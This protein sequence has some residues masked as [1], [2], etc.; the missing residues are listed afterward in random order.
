MARECSF[1]PFPQLAVHTRTTKLAHP[2]VLWRGSQKLTYGPAV[3]A[4]WNGAAAAAA[5]QDKDKGAKG[6][7]DAI[8]R[9]ARIYATWEYEQRFPNEPLPAHRRGRAGT[10]A[11]AGTVQLGAAV[12]PVRSR[13]ASKD[14]A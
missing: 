10:N 2:P 9:D 12:P 8:L 6:A 7:A 14:L 4:P 13:S 3:P 11:G 5:E 1:P